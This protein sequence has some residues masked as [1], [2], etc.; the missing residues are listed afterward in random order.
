ML[1]FL[2][3]FHTGGLAQGPVVLPADQVPVRVAP[4][5]ADRIT[6]LQDAAAARVRE[7]LDR[8][9]AESLETQ[10]CD[11][12]DPWDIF[13]TLYGSYDSEFDDCALDVLRDLRDG[14]PRRRDLPA[15]MLREMFCVA[16]LCDY[17]MSPRS[18]FPTRQFKALLPEL[19]EKWEAYRRMM[20]EDE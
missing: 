20:W 10:S 12:F 6:A 14:E 17:G 19:I 9:M 1:S 13:P 8:P 7:I 4:S 2:K 3:G 5:S 16:D 15:R 18:C 11:N